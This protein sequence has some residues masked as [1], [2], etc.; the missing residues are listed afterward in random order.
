MSLTPDFSEIEQPADVLRV[1]ESVL[2]DANPANVAKSL[3]EGNR[4][5]LLVQARTE[6]M[7]QEHKVESL[8]NFISELQQQ[9]YAQR[10]DLE[11]AHHGYVESR[12]EQVRLQEE[13]VVK[14]KV[15]RETQIQS[16]HEMWEMKRAQEIRVDEFSVQNLRESHETVQRLTSQGQ[17]V[18][19]R[20]NYLNDS[21]ELHEVESNFCGKCSHVPFQP[22]RISS[23]RSMLS[24]DKRLQPETWNPSGPQEN[25][26]CK[27]TFDARVST[28][29]LSR[30]SSHDINCCRSGSRADQHR[31]T[32]GKRGWKKRKPGLWR[33]QGQRLK[34][35]V[36]RLDYQ[37][38]L[39]RQTQI[40][41]PTP[42]QRRVLKD[43]KK[44]LNCSSVQGNLWQRTRIRT[45]WI[46]GK[47]PSAQGNLWQWW[48]MNTKG[49]SGKSKVPKDS[50]DSWPK[51][52]LW[53]H[54]FQ[55][56]PEY[57]PHKE[58]VFSTVRKVYDRKP[59]DK[60]KTQRFWVYSCLS[61]FKLQFILDEII[62]W[63]CDPSRINLRST[64]CQVERWICSLIQCTL[65]DFV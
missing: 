9:A 49:C 54:Q 64:S 31:E 29:T 28:N 32:C 37:G 45:L 19:E 40:E 50:E 27:P 10:L 26:F 39:L 8:N 55:K 30:D 13:L 46:G 36:D 2:R 6:L 23:P 3:L 14:E 11:N 18:Q 42:T 47:N 4:D 21:G 48:W 15:L 51:S 34:V 1:N 38:S 17:E 59:T 22:A 5:H 61:H 60:L 65:V 53:P 12:R 58:K 52:R 16:M 41:I 7:K 25:V 24:C 20:M 44:M 33:S 43:G 56:S 35:Q 62:R 63:I 57:V